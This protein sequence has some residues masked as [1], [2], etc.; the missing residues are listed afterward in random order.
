MTSPT[1]PVNIALFNGYTH[2]A[3]KP[4]KYT[5]VVKFYSTKEYEF[6]CREFI[7]YGDRTSCIKATVKQIKKQFKEYTV[8]RLSRRELRSTHMKTKIIIVDGAFRILFEYYNDLDNF[9]IPCPCT[10]IE[11]AKR[12]LNDFLNTNPIDAEEFKFR[13]VNK[14]SGFEELVNVVELVD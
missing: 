13:Y 7:Q 11:E 1:E 8:I 3:G 6:V 14:D 10:T 5:F 2:A 9:S 12:Y 4:L